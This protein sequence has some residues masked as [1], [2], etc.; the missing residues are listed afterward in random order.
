M[1]KFFCVICSLTLILSLTACGAYFNGSRIGNDSEFNME[2]TVLNA[3]ETQKLIAKSGDTIRAKI[4]LEK[5]SLSIKIQKDGESPI[6]KSNDISTSN[7]F[8]VEI[9]ESGTY[10]VTVAGKNAEGSVSF[11]VESVR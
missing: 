8:D 2:Y 4:V 6:Y 9:N 7:E 3:I 1:K 11:T 10:T 5:G